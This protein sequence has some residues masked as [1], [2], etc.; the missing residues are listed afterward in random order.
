MF[1]A[2]KILFVYNLFGIP[3]AI[4]GIPWTLI[5][6]DISM[7]YRWA[8][9]IANTGLRAGGIRMDVIREE[10]LDPAKRYIFLSNHVSNL[11]PPVLLPLIPGRASVF[12]KR[13]LMKLPVIGYAMK[14]GD[15]IPVDR[16]GRVESAKE[17]VANAVRVLRSGL[18]IMSFVEGTR[19]RDGRLQPF[20]KGPFYLATETGAPVIPVSIWGTESM[21]KKGSLKIYPSTAHVTFHEPL[22]P[23]EFATREDLMGAVRRA[24]ESGL[25]EWMWKNQGVGDRG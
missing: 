19:S 5:T 2:L 15:F 7:L 22:D 17:S 25:P 24:I 23:K 9:W 18:H 4:V 10:P 11:D 6:G 16:D 20:K 1:A 8:M 3:A 21:M 12:L 14:L 13:S